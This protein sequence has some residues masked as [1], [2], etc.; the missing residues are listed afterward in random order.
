MPPVVIFAL[1]HLS[2]LAAFSL[3][4]AGR[5]VVAFTDFDPFCDRDFFEDR[6]VIPLSMLAA[7]LPPDDHE[8]VVAMGFR[9]MNQLRRETCSRLEVLG[10][11]LG[12]FI[13]PNARVWS[14]FQ[15]PQHLMIY[16]GTIV[17]PFVEIG[18]NVTLRANV[19]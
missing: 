3:K 13:S 11:R 2:A 1:S 17:Q 14:G 6:R 12:S 15:S 10:Y 9:R 7:E 19:N 18:N 8:V 4:G 16:E 5:S